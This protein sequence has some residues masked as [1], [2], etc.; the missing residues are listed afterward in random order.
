VDEL[1][2]IVA[3]VAIGKGRALFSGLPR[4]VELDLAEL[5]RL[6][7][8]TFMVRYQVKHSR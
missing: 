8:G 7:D 2:L 4:Q 6:K 1:A 3:P 5:T